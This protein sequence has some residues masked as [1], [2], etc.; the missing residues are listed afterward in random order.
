MLKMIK[1]QEKTP[2]KSS[3]APFGIASTSEGRS[4][5][6]IAM[7]KHVREILALCVPSLAQGI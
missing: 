7:S 4:W 2:K 5:K 6:L 3:S 1:K